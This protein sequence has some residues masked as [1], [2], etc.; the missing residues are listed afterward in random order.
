[1]STTGSFSRAWDYA[2]QLLE[3]GQVRDFEAYKKRSDKEADAIAEADL[4]TSKL[5]ERYH[6]AVVHHRGN[7][8]VRGKLED[9]LK[10]VQNGRT[11]LRMRREVVLYRLNAMQAVERRH[12]VGLGVPALDDLPPEQRERIRT[13]DPDLSPRWGRARSVTQENVVYAL[14]IIKARQEA[15]RPLKGPDELAQEMIKIRKKDCLKAVQ[16]AVGYSELP[17]EEQSLSRLHSL[18]VT[19]VEAARSGDPTYY[20]TKQSQAKADVRRRYSLDRS[21]G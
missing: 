8:Y 12:L 18:L 1:M 10:H 19:H 2:K 11:L 9:R 4:N 16:K 3:G 6:R 21:N 20:E 15:G 5:A 7:E 14:E 13:G 17:S